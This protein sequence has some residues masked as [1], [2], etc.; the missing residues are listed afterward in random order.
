MPICLQATAAVP[1]EKPSEQTGPQTPP[2]NIS[3]LPFPSKLGAPSKDTS[4]SAPPSAPA[5]ESARALQK[6]TA[7]SSRCRQTS[8]GADHQHLTVPRHAH[9]QRLSQPLPHL[10]PSH[11]TDGESKKQKQIHPCDARLAHEAAH[12]QTLHRGRCHM[13]TETAPPHHP[14]DRQLSW[15]ALLMPSR[16]PLALAPALARMPYHIQGAVPSERPQQKALS[17]TRAYPKNLSRASLLPPASEQSC[18]TSL[19]AEAITRAPSPR[20]PAG[21]EAGGGGAGGVCGKWGLPAGGDPPS[22]AAGKHPTAPP[23]ASLEG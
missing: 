16:L 2:R 6:T 5:A 22:P 20:F 17:S 8:S 7:S 15:L 23:D 12:C 19:A 4:L 1:T 21:G 14:S 13:H 18:A 10:R 9:N 3:S 11:A